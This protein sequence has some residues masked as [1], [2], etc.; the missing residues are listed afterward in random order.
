MCG[1]WSQTDLTL[2]PNSW[3]TLGKL[4]NLSKCSLPCAA[5]VNIAGLTPVLGKGSLQ[6][7]PLILERFSPLTDDE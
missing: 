6:G 5:G 1:I 4:L 7:W 3:I 2:S